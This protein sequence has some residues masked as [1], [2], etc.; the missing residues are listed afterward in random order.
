MPS[1]AE[2]L[3]DRLLAHGVDT[4]FG[5]PGVHTVEF[6]RAIADGRMRHITPRHEQGAGL[7]AYGYALA[8]GRPAACSFITGAGMTNAAT[9]I[10]QAYSDSV[11]MLVVTSGSKLH[12]L[13][14]GIGS[15]HELP[16]QDLVEAQLAGYSH[17]VLDPSTVGEAVDRAFAMIH[18]SR[19][20]PAV[21]Q[22]PRDLFAA[23]AAASAA[24]ATMVSPPGPDAAT[25]ERIHQ[26]I[27]SAQ[28][29][30]LVLGGGVRRV[31]SQARA[32]AERLGAPVVT[33]IAGKGML[34][35]DH[36]LD[37]GSTL[38]CAPVQKLTAESDLMIAVG[39][40]LAPTDLF[41][42][43][44]GIDFSGD[45]VRI[46]IDT[47]QLVRGFPPAIALQSE[48][49]R[50]FDALLQVLADPS[51]ERVKQSQVRVATARASLTAEISEF[52]RSH[53]VVL[54]AIRDA[55][56][57]DCFI[58][59]DSTQIA[60]TGSQWYRARRPGTWHFP[61]GYGTLGT[62]LPAAMGAKIGAPDRAAI[63][64]AGDGGFL[65][66][67]AELATAAQLGLALPIVLWN[68]NGYREIEGA[69]RRANVPPT[70]VELGDPD[71][72]MIA[73][74]FG[75]HAERIE[76]L[77][78]LRDG[79]ARALKADRPTLLEIKVDGQL[80]EN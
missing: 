47:A 15:L 34:G 70:G 59:A 71:F 5:I 37:L 63:A 66:T 33:T 56:P 48:A 45:L 29:P 3:V 57:A 9:A 68:N 61:S 73:R 32:F 74:G 27:N 1:T 76:S 35:E 79:I 16:R 54:E 78:A 52:E 2:V 26:A 77:S 21:I 17:R 8:T 72:Q 44:G 51:A 23:D 10:A 18:G 39:T 31:A 49:G 53:I 50:A 65:F 24:P 43:D 80:S 7:M 22:V 20:R 64:I 69:M 41:Q 12:E 14:R 36:P 25:I 62:G 6:Y 46:D 58:S 67:I 38:A 40:E 75:C 28:R 42:T 60:Y 11:P 13:E 19:S 55:V 4:V 30:L